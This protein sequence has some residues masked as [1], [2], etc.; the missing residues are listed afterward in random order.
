ME[1]E[2]AKAEH[3]DTRVPPVS[4]VR[5]LATGKP[6]AALQ[7][8]RRFLLT[9]PLRI[10]QGALQTVGLSAEH[11]RRLAAAL[12]FPISDRTYRQFYDRIILPKLEKEEREEN[13][14]D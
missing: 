3:R 4:I 6:E 9:R 13:P 1:N 11:R 5:H 10:P 14:N 8:A 7:T 2:A 12:C